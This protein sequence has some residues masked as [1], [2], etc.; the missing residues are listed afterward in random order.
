MSM[1]ILKMFSKFPR[2]ETIPAGRV[3]ICI[4]SGSYPRLQIKTCIAIN[5][6]S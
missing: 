1:L 4:G 6:N 5:I 3:S 2:L